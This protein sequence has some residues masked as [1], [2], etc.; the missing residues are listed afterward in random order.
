[1]DEKVT[2]VVRGADLIEMT[3]I[4]K[5]LYKELKQDAPSYLHLPL[6]KMNN[7]LK[8]S[9][10]NHAAAALKLGSPQEVLLKCLKLLNQNTSFYKEGM[11]A[12]HILFCAAQGFDLKKIPSASLIVTPQT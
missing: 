11:S 1:M 10:Q 3:P 5:L 9:K 7:E 4:Q 2:E 12:E 8:Y 6:I